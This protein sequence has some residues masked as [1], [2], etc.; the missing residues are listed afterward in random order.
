VE[1]ELKQDILGYSV[2]GRSLA[3]C[4]KEIE[5]VAT[6]GRGCRW[7]ACINPHSYAVAKRR[8][9]FAAALRAADWLVPDGVG[10]AIAGRALG[11]PLAGRI[12]GMD[13]FQGV[14]ACA[15]QTGASV[16]FLGSTPETIALL[17]ARV[18]KDY[19]NARCLGGF[20]PPFQEEFDPHVS[21]RMVDAVNRARPDILWVGLT[22]PKQEIW[23]ATHRHR[24]DSGFAGA[25]GAVFDFY[26]GRVRRSSPAFRNAGL[27]WLPRLAREPRRLW[28]RTFV[29]APL[30]LADV[31]LERWRSAVR[32]D[33][34]IAK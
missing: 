14:M 3:A 23:L 27:E 16:F 18:A 32:H 17:E 20:S 1:G 13:I 34:A 24:L 15:D 31:A 29:S 19:P 26:S 28:R 7:L 10:I 4:L 6:H 2:D 33:D 22:A 5:Q 9:A 11:R 8:P 30:F 25:I 21:E 12:T